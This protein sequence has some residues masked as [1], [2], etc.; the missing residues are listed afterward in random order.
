MTVT[1]FGKPAGTPATTTPAAAAPATAGGGGRYSGLKAAG[2]GGPPMP[3]PGTYTFRLVK[4]FED[5][6]KKSKNY[7]YQ[8]YF[9]IVE[10]LEGGIGHKVG[11]VVKFLQVTSG[12]G[13]LTGGGKVKS[14]LMA[15]GGFE[16]EADYDAYD[17][18][19]KFIEACGGA[20]VP[21]YNADAAAMKGRLVRAVVE[22]GNDNPKKPGDWFREYRWTIVPEED[23]PQAA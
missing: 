4:A 7:N 19:G 9:E 1:R 21:Q 23:Q 3:N 10:I 12:S 5:L 11:D 2:S 16:T 14:A 18:E 22:R 20:S 6:G 17:P 8:I 15:V 13:A